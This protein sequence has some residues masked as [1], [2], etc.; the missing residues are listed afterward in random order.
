MSRIFFT[1][2]LDPNEQFHEKKSRT[3]LKRIKIQNRERKSGGGGVCLSSFTTE[4]ICV[5]FLKYQ[6]NIYVIALFCL[7]YSFFVFR[8]GK[9]NV[10]TF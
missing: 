5:V 2:V 4:P 1:V 8:F 3:K 6:R 7:I 9:I 10:L